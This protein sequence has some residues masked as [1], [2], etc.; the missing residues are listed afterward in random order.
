MLVRLAICLLAMPGMALANETATLKNCASV[1][2][3]K[4]EPGRVYITD[5]PGKD[6]RVV[7]RVTCH[8]GVTPQQPSVS[9]GT[10]E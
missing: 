4:W 3:E 6:Y 5:K 10:G 2:V 1:T 9:Q 7:I 8:G